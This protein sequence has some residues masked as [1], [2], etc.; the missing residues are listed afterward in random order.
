M[1]LRISWVKGSKISQATKVE[2]FGSAGM[3]WGATSQAY[4]ESLAKALADSY[5]QAGHTFFSSATIVP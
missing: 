1:I 4:S 2:G 3:N 5:Y